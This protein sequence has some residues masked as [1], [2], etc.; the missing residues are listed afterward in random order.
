MEPNRPNIAT[1]GSTYVSNVRN[2]GS[3]GTQ[4]MQSTG[5]VVGARTWQGRNVFAYETSALGSIMTEPESGRWIAIVKGDAPVTSWE[6]PVGWDFPLEV[7]KTGTK[8]YRMTNHVTKRTFDYESTWRVD[9]YED[10]TVP[11]GTF[12]CY[13]VV[14]NSTLGD[15]NV[16]WWSPDLGIFVKANNRRTEK[17]PAGPGTNDSELASQKIT[18]AR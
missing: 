17:H 3:Y 18:T 10:V 11:A 13:K 7:G 8:K 2:T 14:T 5:R 9:A 16:T 12:K 4:T 6:P 1:A 15:A